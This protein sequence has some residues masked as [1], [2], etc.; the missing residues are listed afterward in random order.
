MG[1][2]YT[3]DVTCKILPEHVDFIS[4]KYIYNFTIDSDEEDDVPPISSLKKIYREILSLWGPLDLNYFHEHELGPDN[5][6]TCQISKKVIN[7]R[8]DLWED[9]LTFVKEILVPLSSEITFCRIMSDDFGDRTQLYTDLELRNGH[10]NLQQLIKYLKHTYDEDGDI[11][12]T[13]IIYKRSIKKLQ[14][15]D[16]DRA[17]LGH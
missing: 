14:A 3:L 2:Y 11:V 9:L 13:R 12:E 5:T 7:H 1:W 8:G 16:L 17:Y 6:F 10:L 4:K 15:L